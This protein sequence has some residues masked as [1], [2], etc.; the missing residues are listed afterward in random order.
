MSISNITGFGKM[1]ENGGSGSTIYMNTTDSLVI[2]NINIKINFITK[3]F[4]NSLAPVTA[5]KNYILVNGI[6]IG[7]NPSYRMIPASGILYT[8]STIGSIYG[9][10][11]SMNKLYVMVS[12]YDSTNGGRYG[13]LELNTDFYIYSKEM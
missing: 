8:A 7:T 6:D 2:S 4:I 3:S 11:Y 5:I 10:K 1:E 12:L 13:E 9:I